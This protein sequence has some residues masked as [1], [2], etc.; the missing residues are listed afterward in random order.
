MIAMALMCEPDL[1]IA[2]EPTTALDVT[3]QMQVL[4]LLKRLQ[5]E[6]GLAVILITHDLG[7]VARVADRVLVMYAGE[8]VEAGPTRALFDKPSHPYTQGLLRCLP[9][10]TEGA[11]DD[12]RLG[13]ISGIVPSLIGE[14]RGCAFANRCPHAFEACR[15]DDI[16]DA[17]AG[18]GHSY[19]CLLPLR[20]SQA[21]FDGAAG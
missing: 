11:G 18:A 14:F 15:R 3:I 4:S 1:I 20:L 5:R 19:R 21:N 9:H 12:A 7:V 8:I 10:L 17:S 6:L 13:T 2:D 16:A